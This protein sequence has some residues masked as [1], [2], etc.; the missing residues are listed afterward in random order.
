VKQDYAIAR[1]WFE[2]AAGGA[3]ATKAPG[4]IARR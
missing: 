1:L 2:K 4:D 3:D